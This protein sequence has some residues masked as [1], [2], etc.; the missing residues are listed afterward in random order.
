MTR[1]RRPLAWY[2]DWMLGDS[3]SDSIASTRCKVVGDL[4]DAVQSGHFDSQTLEEITLLLDHECLCLELVR[5]G[6]N[7]RAEAL[8]APWTSRLV[9]QLSSRLSQTVYPSLSLERELQFRALLSALALQRAQSVAA[10][11]PD[12]HKLIND[13]ITKRFSEL[14]WQQMTSSGDLTPERYRKYQASF[15]LSA[16]GEYVKS[17]DQAQPLVVALLSRAMNIIL[18]GGSVAMAITTVFSQNK[19]AIRCCIKLLNTAQGTGSG[20]L[21][22]MF[23]A[24]DEAFK[25]LSETP[26]KNFED[27]FTLQDLTRLTLASQVR[28][29]VKRDSIVTVQHRVTNYA[30]MLKYSPQDLA[31]WIFRRI[32]FTINRIGQP[33][34]NTSS[35]PVKLDYVRAFMDRG[36]PSFDKYFYVYGLL[37]TASQLSRVIDPGKIPLDLELRMKNIIEQSKEASYRW[38]AVSSSSVMYPYAEFLIVVYR[39]SFFYRIRRLETRKLPN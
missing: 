28:L 17:F 31:E 6:Q 4:Q 30:Q 8:Q 11:Q 18:T 35:P 38:K 7:A 16:T 15:L 9:V 22:S 1:L 29:T 25:P 19:Y 26:N 37:D 10:F 39:S 24:L 20:D 2:A 21:R 36:P 5:I 14:Q 33:E 12:H 3:A 23:R 13:Q 32:L 27:L 34:K